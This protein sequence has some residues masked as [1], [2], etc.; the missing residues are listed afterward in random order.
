MSESAKHYAEND[1][2]TM[3]AGIVALAQH[4]GKLTRNWSK[5]V[6]RINRDRGIDLDAVR[7]RAARNYRTAHAADMRR[8]RRRHRTPIT[9]GR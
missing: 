1:V 8:L 9:R 2:R 5:D 6:D 4:D 3:N 7:A